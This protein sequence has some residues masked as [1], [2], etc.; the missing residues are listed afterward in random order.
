MDGPRGL[1]QA[2][3]SF[4][5]SSE[6]GQN[7]KT[8]GFT[9]Q[10]IWFVAHPP[11]KKKAYQPTYPLVHSAMAKQ[12]YQKLPKQPKVLWVCLE[13]SLR[14]IEKMPKRKGLLVP[15]FGLWRSIPSIHRR[16][17]VLGPVKYPG[18]SAAPLTPRRPC[19]PPAWRAIFD[20]FFQDKVPKI[21]KPKFS[22]K[23]PDHRGGGS[24]QFFL[25]KFLARPSPKLRT[26]SSYRTLPGPWQVLLV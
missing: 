9:L 24:S 23:K 10:R 3:T 12:L 18:G 2:T 20:L 22:P 1:H 17:E 7:V 14:G 21:F 13:K 15:G 11:Q 16:R 5:L 6:I 4:R 26:P 25:K 8:R 19:D